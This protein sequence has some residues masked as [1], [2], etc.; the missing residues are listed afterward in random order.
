MGKGLLGIIILAIIT[1]FMALVWP[2]S[3]NQRSAEMG[4]TIQS[5][6]NANGY[7]FATVNMTGNVA[8]LTGEAPSA[9]AMGSAVALATTT[10]CEACESKNTWHEVASDLTVKEVKVVP[11]TPFTFSAVK[12]AEGQVTLDGYVRNDAERNRVLREAETLFAGN[13]TDRTI[14]VAAGAPNDSWGDVVSLNLA[15]LKLLDRGRFNME[16]NQT[17]ISGLASGE[18]VRSAV[19]AMVGK[20]P[21]GYEG[22][23]NIDV[24]GAAAINV[25][26]VKSEGICQALF[27]DLK[28]DNKI[29]FSTARADIRGAESYDLLTKLASA[30]KQCASFRVS[31]V[32]HTDSDGGEVANQA[33]SEARA[34]QVV[35]YLAQNGVELSRLSAEGKGETA[36][37]ATNDTSEG[38]AQNRRIEFLVTQAN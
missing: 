5:A 8:R 35:A 19:N 1:L 22:A 10:K 33:L 31:I 9:E 6:L 20:L 17:F 4:Q 29:N 7:D 28:G 11:V 36:P 32:G 16:N 34:N 37:I 3:A 18:E 15:E 24:P 30:A 27:N 23:A 2:F 25:G 26:E 14:K 21:V 13:V 12:T 38:K